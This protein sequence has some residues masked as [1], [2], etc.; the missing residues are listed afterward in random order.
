MRR[1]EQGEQLPHAADLMFIPQRLL[2]PILCPGR[3]L[4]S[5][6]KQ[7]VDRNLW[8]PEASCSG[9]EYLKGCH[10]LESVDGV[11]GEGGLLRGRE[12]REGVSPVGISGRLFQ[13]QGRA[14]VKAIRSERRAR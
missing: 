3:V 1:D 14:K 5:G 4:G 2:Q 7:S 9:G 12:G 6:D 8:P 13:A 10:D 11:A